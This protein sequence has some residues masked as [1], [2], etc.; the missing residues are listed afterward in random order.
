VRCITN[1]H[2]QALTVAAKE[3]PDE[4]Q[5]TTIYTN[6]VCQAKFNVAVADIYSSLLGGS[7]PSADQLIAA[8]DEMIGDWHANL[9]GFFTEKV[10]QEARFVLCHAILH[11]RPRNFRIIM[12]RPFLIQ[13]I[14]LQNSCQ[15]PSRRESN[16]E[17][18]TITAAI[19]RC[20]DAASETIQE[21]E[22]LM[23][24]VAKSQMAYWYMLY[25]LFPAA[26]IPLLCVRHDANAD[27]ARHWDE[28]VT[29]A[30]R[31]MKTIE[32]L[33][34]TAKRGVQII[35]SLRP[36]AV[37]MRTVSEDGA[38]DRLELEMSSMSALF[39]PQEDSRMEFAHPTWFE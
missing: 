8:D 32:P 39:Q 4:A 12:Y 26:I 5:E 27:D 3:M 30:V 24:R 21:I 35:Q 31:L 18:E 34:P 14:M 23:S 28:Q 9:P 36:T 38:S 20:Q 6:L 11:L 37:A 1:I 17:F 25:F 16:V 19:R 29:R 15:E 33:V 7:Y 10:P 22:S 2:T 13:R